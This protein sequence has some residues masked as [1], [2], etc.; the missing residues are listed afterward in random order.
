LALLAPTPQLFD[1]ASGNDPARA[2]LAWQKEFVVNGD[3]GTPRQTLYPRLPDKFYGPSLADRAQNWLS[4]TPD[5]APLVSQRDDRSLLEIMMTMKA[6]R[7]V[8]ISSSAA[9]CI[10]ITVIFIIIITTV[11]GV[12]VLTMARYESTVHLI[13]RWRVDRG[14]AG[15]PRLLCRVPHHTRLALL[16]HVQ[17]GLGLW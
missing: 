15:I 4:R 5:R 12:F 10:T 6:I 7:S 8:F 17:P 13:S 1:V 16:G 11:T 9:I 14:L 2:K 3:L